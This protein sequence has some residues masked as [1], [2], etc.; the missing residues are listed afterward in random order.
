VQ[1]TPALLHVFRD[2]AA[3]KLNKGGFSQRD[4]LPAA[5]LSKLATQ[6]ERLHIGS[7]IVK[8]KRESLFSASAFSTTGN[9]MAKIT[10]MTYATVGQAVISH[11]SPKVSHTLHFPYGLS[12]NRAC[13]LTML[14]KSIGDKIA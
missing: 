7:R 8:E 1:G 3:N 12:S 11:A 5:S 6:L 14:G 9:M 2:E 13:G 10:P 4:S